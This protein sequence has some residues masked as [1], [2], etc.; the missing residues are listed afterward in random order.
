M[1]TGGSSTQ[2]EALSGELIRGSNSALSSSYSI[3]ELER[4]RASHEDRMRAYD[5]IDTV[6][7]SAVEVM[8]S[9]REIFQCA[10]RCYLATIE[11]RLTIE[12]YR[13]DAQRSKDKLDKVVPMY[14]RQLE[15]LSTMAE[16]ALDD[17]LKIEPSKCSTPELQHRTEILRTARAL[18]DNITDLMLQLVSI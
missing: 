15:R 14:E 2:I 6:A 10:E 1:A 16:R 17:A 8:S 4:M 13:I 7:Q 5:T 18:T 3:A 9:T 11:F 12:R